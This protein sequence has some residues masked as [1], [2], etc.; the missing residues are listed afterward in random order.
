MKLILICIAPFLVIGLGFLIF[1]VFK[2]ILGQHKKQVKVVEQV[3]N[4]Q[5]I[6]DKIAQ[7]AGNEVSYPS[8]KSINLNIKDFFRTEEKFKSITETDWI[9][10][11]PSSAYEGFIEA[12]FQKVG[13]AM[14]KKLNK[15]EFF[16][17]I[18][19]YTYNIDFQE[20]LQGGDIR[21]NKQLIKESCSKRTFVFDFPPYLNFEQLKNVSLY[22]LLF[23][24]TCL[25][26][27][28]IQYQNIEG[29]PRS[30]L[31]IWGFLLSL[32]SG[33]VTIFSAG[34]L[35]IKYFANNLL[36]QGSLLFI[37]NQ[38][39][40]SIIGGPYLFIYMMSFYQKNIQA[41]PSFTSPLII[42]VILI[43]IVLIVNSKIEAH[44]KL[45][46]DLFLRL[47]QKTIIE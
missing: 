4:K 11:V 47:L 18:F 22:Y 31:L 3:P 44:K 12:V 41:T 43:T 6:Y 19:D 38:I 29:L 10:K 21:V 25:A 45:C 39:L 32:S 40:M 33:L 20:S 17:M 15:Q 7:I 34:R 5:K 14:P 28:F 24:V 36:I 2:N 16:K 30:I 9:Y 27:A 13:E 37:L 46:D 23:T 35:S 1:F 42:F 26:I 8:V